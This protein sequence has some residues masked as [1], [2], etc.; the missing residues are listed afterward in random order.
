MRINACERC[1]NGP[2]LPRDGP[3]MLPIIAVISARGQEGLSSHGWRGAPR[4]VSGTER[5][6]TSA[7][8]P[9]PRGISHRSVYNDHGRGCHEIDARADLGQQDGQGKTGRHDPDQIGPRRPSLRRPHASSASSVVHGGSR[10]QVRS[11]RITHPVSPSE[12]VSSLA[13]ALVPCG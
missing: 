10:Q 13:P 1:L 12:R 8:Q 2:R 11:M 4:S 9:Q 3:E 6:H 5:P 7:P